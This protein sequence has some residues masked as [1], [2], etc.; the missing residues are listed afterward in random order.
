M[1]LQEQTSRS[2]LHETARKRP[3]QLTDADVVEI[4]STFSELGHWRHDL[5]T[6]HTYCCETLL[7]FFGLAPTDGPVSMTEISAG[8]HP[9]DLSYVM[10]AHESASAQPMAYRK[11]HR[12]GKN[13]Q[14]YRWYCST[15]RFRPKAGTSGE[16]VGL[17]WE[18]PPQRC[19]T[20]NR[21]MDAI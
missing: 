7:G 9:D 20:T 5:D 16:I 17:T 12:I 10:E 11:I 8:L 1:L 4:F 21:L 14:G 2:T 18:I 6:G 15:G 19:E 13:G 3:F